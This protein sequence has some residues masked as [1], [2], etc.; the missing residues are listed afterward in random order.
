M[1]E[2]I[3]VSLFE[4]L[5]AGLPAELPVFRASKT[6]LVDVS[7]TLEDLVLR[8]SLPSVMFTGFQESSHWQEETERYLQLAGIA[9]Q[10]CIFAGGEPPVPEERHIAVT[11]RSDDP[12][13]QEWFL[14]VLTDHFAALLCGQDRQERV[15]TEQQRSFDTIFTLAPQLI[16]RCIDLLLDVVR[17][18]RPDRAAE[19]AEA[20]ERFAPRD[21]SGVYA[22]RMTTMFLD[23]MQRRQNLLQDALVQKERLETAALALERTLVELAVP[24]IPLVPDVI[25]VPLVGNIDSRRAQQITESLLEGIA[26]QQADVAILD[27]TGV[28]LIDTGVANHL[29]QTVRAANLLGARI[30]LTGIGADIAQ[31]LVHLDVD[32]SMIQTRA[33]LQTGIEAA[34]AFQGLRIAPLS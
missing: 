34:L 20:R 12:L 16:E 2:P 15:E 31:T 11:L 1:P 33:N 17:S 6:T 25:V 22:T 18:Y 10:I 8:D 14:L 19:L 29:I 32:F 30:I 5:R 23:H 3:R 27:I 9:Q 26:R 21:P 4:H 28:P 7:H 24:V 13:R